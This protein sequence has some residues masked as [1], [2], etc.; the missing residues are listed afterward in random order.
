MDDLNNVFE[1]ADVEETALNTAVD[2][3]HKVIIS[4][5]DFRPS[6]CDTMANLARGLLNKIDNAGH[7]I[8]EFTNTLCT[9]SAD[10]KAQLLMEFIGLDFGVNEKA[11]LLKMA[12]WMGPDYLEYLRRAVAF[13]VKV[14]SF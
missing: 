7:D 10:M 9:L 14:E 8:S 2:T 4:R 5:S 12:H 11:E 13:M 3:L 1:Q 6:E